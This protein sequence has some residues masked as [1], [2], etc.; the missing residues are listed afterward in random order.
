MISDRLIRIHEAVMASTIAA[1]LNTL[2]LENLHGK[3]ILKL[4]TSEKF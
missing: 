4:M 3:I 1:L 2:E